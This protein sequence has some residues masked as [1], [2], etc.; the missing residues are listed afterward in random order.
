MLTRRTRFS[1]L[2]PRETRSIM[3][4]SR[5]RGSHVLRAVRLAGETRKNIP[6]SSQLSQQ[7]RARRCRF[8]DRVNPDWRSTSENPSVRKLNVD[9]EFVDTRQCQL[10]NFGNP[11]PP[12]SSMLQEG[13]NRNRF[14]TRLITNLRRRKCRCVAFVV[15]N[16][17]FTMV[18]SLLPSS[19]IQLE[20]NIRNDGR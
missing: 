8:E 12:W 13:Q 15:S 6:N 2:R 1:R 5:P 11:T 4:F 7:L 3:H 14:A 9:S 10:V 16:Y 20:L 18:N 19:T 17:E